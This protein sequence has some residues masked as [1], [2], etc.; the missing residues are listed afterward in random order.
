MLFKS[1]L[2]VILSFFLSIYQVNLYAQNKVVVTLKGLKSGDTALLRIQKSGEEFKFKYVGGTGSDIIHTFDTLSNGKWALSVDA[3][4]YIFPTAAVIQLNNN[5]FASTV[6]LTKS[7]VDSNFNYQWQ[8]DSSYVGHAQQAYINDKV[9]IVVL[10]KAEKVPDDF[11]AINALNEYGFLFSDEESKW[12]SEDSY[13]LYQTLKKFNYQKFGE[14][15]LV[16]VKSKWILTDKY[17][18]RDIDFKTVSGVDVITIS[19]AAFTY[20]TPQT[21]TVDGVKGKFFSKR[22]FTSLVYYYTDKGTKKDKI[23]ELA[24]TRYGFEFLVPSTFLKN[25]MGETE[26]NFQEFTSDEKIVILSMFEEFPDAMQRQAE[27]KYMVRRVNGQSHPVYPPAPAIAWVTNSNIEWMESA[28]KS[29]DITYMQRLVLHEKAHFLW[30]HTFDK[31]TQDDWAT[32]GGWSKDPA[33]LSGWSTNNTTEFVSAYAHLKNPNED[34]A[35]SIAFFITNPEAFRSRSLKKFEFVRDRI[36]KGTRYI[37]VIR[38]DLTFQVYNLFPDYNYPGKIKRTKL[39]VV[40]APNED[41]IVKLEIELN[42]MNKA[43]DGAEW[44]GCTFFSS[45][46]TLKGMYLKPINAEKSI[47]RGEITLSKFAKSGY[48]I[49]PQMTIG[50]LQGNMRLENNSTYGVKCFVNN[51]LEDVTAP[52]YVQKSLTMDSVSVKLIDFTGSLAVDR[53]GPCADTITPSTAIKFKFK[54]EEKNKINPD[55]RAYARVYLPS[56]DSTDK[57]N[58]QPYSFDVQI[59]GNGI[60]NDFTDSIKTAQFYFPVP[61]YYPSGF[62][63]VNYLLMMDQALNVRQTFFDKDTAN[64]NLFMPPA[65]V[66]QRSLRDSI[67]IRTKYPDLKPPLLDL[68]DIQIKATPTNPVSPNGETLFEMWLWVKDES[69][70]VGKASGF[71]NGY[72]VLR[73][74]Q[75]LETYVS[76]QRDLGNTFYNIK[77]DSSIYGYKRYYFK[78]L[79]PVGSPPGLWGVSA[80]GLNDHAQNKKYYSFVEYV[81]FD[82]EQSKV[83]QVT[84]YVEIL[85]KRVN[86]KNVDSVSVKIGCKSCINQN[87]RLRMYSSMGGTSVVSEGKMTKDTITVSNLNLKGV[88]DGVLYATAFMLD[89]TKALIGTGKATYTKDATVPTNYNLTPNRSLLG[90]SNLDSFIVAIKSVEINSSNLVV[91]KQTTINP[92]STGQIGD[93]IVLNSIRNIYTANLPVIN[94]TAQNRTGNQFNLESEGGMPS[95]LMNTGFYDS[96]L[97]I[98]KSVFDKLADGT[99]EIKLISTDSVGNNGL[100]VSQFI[101]KDTKS[102]ALNIV[103]DS[104]IGLKKYVRLVSDE[105]IANTP[106][107][108]DFVVSNGVIN[109]ITKLNSKTFGLVITKSCNNN[110]NIQLNGSVLQDSVGNS[111]TTVTSSFNDNIVPA[112]P[113]VSAST[114]TTFCEGGT[115]SLTSN[116]TSG[117]QWFKDGQIISGSVG[118]QYVASASG[119]YTVISTNSNGCT[120]PVSSVVVVTVNP[121]PSAPV[122]A[123][124]AVCEGVAVNALTATAS[125]GNSLRWYGTSATGGTV[126]SSAP[127]PSTSAAGVTNFYV[128]Q[129]TAQ[130]CESERSALAYTVHP[131]PSAPVTAAS[132]VCEGGVVSALTATASTG[133]SLRWYGTSAT[134]GTASTTAPTPSSSSAGVTN[135]YVT[136]ITAQGCESE[137]SVLAYTVHPK[138]SAPVTAASAVCEGGVVSALTAT[139]STGNSLRWYG[140]S[141]TGGTAS[142]LAPTV[143]SSVVGVTNYYV[144]QVSAQG[145]ESGR[146]ILVHTVNPLPAKPVISWSGV[147]FSTTATGVNYQWLLNGALVAGATASTHK[148]LNIGEFRLRVT[149]PNGCI[150]VSDSFK[151]VVTALANLV[152]TPSSNIA[153]V[154]PNPA[155]NKVVLEFATLPTIN[156]NF[157][158]VSPSGKVF[159]STTGRNKVNIIDV[160]D[161]QSGNYFIRVIG[162]KYDQV[163]KVIIKK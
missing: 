124:S 25:L 135:F 80:I 63:S 73:D 119:S 27:L 125:T 126:S 155:S 56:F 16:R 133:N 120:S 150:N 153:T 61:D 139:A 1:K 99:I 159:S 44:A 49:I 19:R 32:L 31:T 148:P 17:I 127:I 79:L 23:A 52:L 43:F 71:A 107:I 51:P 132:A 92:G 7:P 67:Y 109:T 4:T 154:Y 14:N 68:N 42:I 84:P 53:C 58:I 97:R 55:G 69:D 33:A 102:P 93:S 36:M 96:T 9:E 157:Q 40:G 39:E 62:Y 121:K 29:Q 134:V 2:I 129:I 78:T 136:Q 130:G 37:S 138:P 70:F 101:Y 143:S 100:S 65:F 77:P 113:I 89:S 5:S 144:S 147:Q 13:R 3:K 151:L 30:E 45:I 115:V 110:L 8:D 88:N 163:K 76:M 118:T 82:V 60:L 22:L 24:K 108:S 75:G 103:S 95:A 46:G 47:L 41:K 59:N 10:G 160:S 140:T 122:T 149:D 114:V 72:Y 85:G 104:L 50:D 35:E 146:S 152:T 11:N 91:L 74:P 161:I 34:M 66:N 116:A 156:L 83:L 18:D 162:K 145:C 94:S 48:W 98:P 90:K 28:F 21:V 6:Q 142:T 106:A 123:A 87:Y 20:A 54:I 112:T 131:K 128:S 81:R 57:Y 64:K 105:F 117:N 38:P 12:T 15:E 26:T 86:S 158:L 141:A 111:N 137:R